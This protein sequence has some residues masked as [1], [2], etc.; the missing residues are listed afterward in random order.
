M[1]RFLL[2]P[3]FDIETGRLLSHDGEFFEEPKI[4]FDRGAVGQAKQQGKVAGEVAGTAG[5]N[6]SQI[7]STITPVLEQQATHPTGYDPTTL[8]NM[9]VSQ[10]EAAGGANAT[11]GGEGR[12]NALRTRTA[13]GFAP[14]LA[15][16]ARSK[17]RTL[18][19][20]ALNVQNRS[21]DLAQQ[22]QQEALRSLQGLYG[23]DTSNQLKAMG[24]QSEDLQNQLAAGRQG[25]LQNTEGV[26]GTIGK[27][28]SEA[29]GAYG[30]VK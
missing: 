21:A 23:T 10:Q 4:L 1:A 7:G 26:L 20:G 27:L 6:A 25:W 24:L 29:A 2:N 16:A 30:A 11:V 14:A 5:S 22:K 8:N 12:L 15:E 3:T 9:L 19:T 17:G 18:A 13:G 28:G